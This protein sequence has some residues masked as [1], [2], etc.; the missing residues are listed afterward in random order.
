MVDPQHWE[1]ALTAYLT[2]AGAAQDETLVVLAQAVMAEA[3]PVGSSSGVYSVG[4]RGYRSGIATLRLTILDRDL[5]DAD[6]AEGSSVSG[7]GGVTG[8]PAF[9]QRN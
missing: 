4:H 6:H 3:D 1:P 9:F 2:Q 5:P 7:Q 8:C